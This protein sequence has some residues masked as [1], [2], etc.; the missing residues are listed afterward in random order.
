MVYTTTFARMVQGGGLIELDPSR[1]R[2]NLLPLG[3]PPPPGEANVQILRGW[4]RRRAFIFLRGSWRL[5][6]L[7]SPRGAIF[8]CCRSAV[9]DYKVHGAETDARAAAP[10]IFGNLADRFGCK[11]GMAPGSVDLAWLRS[12][13]PCGAGGGGGVR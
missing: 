8:G 11:G 6:K 4:Q 9:L 13:S 1:R 10:V 2:T 3:P 5:G 12:S 7:S